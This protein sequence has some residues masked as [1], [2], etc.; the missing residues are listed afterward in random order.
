M[1]PNPPAPPSDA[2][3]LV[4]F[5]LSGSGKSALLGALGQVSQA[6][7][8]LL[9]GK[10]EDR[11]GTLA[12]AGGDH[13]KGEV[14]AHPIHYIPGQ[15]AGSTRD[16][17][18][19]LVDSAGSAASSL[20]T[21][22]KGLDDD[23]PEGS[24]AYEVGDADALILVLDASTPANQV[25]G[26]FAEFARF[27]ETVQ[28]ARGARTEVAGMPVFLVLNKCDK[29]SER[30]DTLSSWM[31]RIEQRKRDLAERFKAFLAEREDEEPAHP[32]DEEPSEEEQ[33]QE[34]QTYTGTFG[35]IELHVWATAVRK[36]DFGGKGGSHEPYGVAELFRQALAEGGEYQERCARAQRRLW[37]VSAVAVALVAVMLAI[38][39]GLFA[40]HRNTQ[41]TMLESRVRDFEFVNALGSRP[42]LRASVD[43]LRI[44]KS[45]LEEIEANRYYPQLEPEVRDRVES[46]H[47]EFGDYIAF[48]E[49]LEARRSPTSEQAESAL[50][51]SLKQLR[52]DRAAL[53]EKWKE[54]AVAPM[55]EERVRAGE[56]LQKAVGVARNW[57]LDSQEE[58]DRL[59]RVDGLDW[60]KW[61]EQVEKL[62][63]ASY[64]PPFRPN[65]PIPGAPGTSLTYAVAIRFDTATKAR[66]GWLDARKRLRRLF[67]LTSALKLTTPLEF[68]APP[69]L[70]FSADFRLAA[71]RPRLAQLEATYPEYKK[72]FLWDEV[73][74][75]LR[76]AVQKAARAQYE[77]LLKVG[78]DEVLARYRLS[79]KGEETAARWEAV[80]V[81]LNAPAELA[82]W[83]ELSLALLRVMSAT[84]EDPVTE[85][86]SFL[87]TKTFAV[88]LESVVVEVPDRSEL[89]P[90]AGARLIVLHPASMRQPALAFEDSGSEVRDEARGVV[91]YT[92]RRVGPK[93]LDYRPGDALWAE[94]PLAGG[95]EKLVW[96]TSRSQ[97]YLID[98]LRNPPLRQSVGATSLGEGKAQPEVRLTGRPEEGLPSVPDLLPA[99]NAPE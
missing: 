71:A 5:G 58:A 52:A 76:P 27:L 96:S 1:T 34:M 48:F 63:G 83:R 62:L 42:G 70:D 68:K 56:A 30:G 91:R 25:E 82:A 8:N 41:V 47:K 18:A 78:R 32:P 43:Q 54:T 66:E 46:T 49:T 17:E 60:T 97:L 23:S 55:L 85:L 33:I 79:G 74:A 61:S 15:A 84:V 12:G 95:K 14:T 93:R 40:L 21:R 67:A 28:K 86:A 98:R 26:Q 29:L 3:R 99:V 39:V 77:R 44:K 22:Q 36:P 50:E 4:L 16:I 51:E 59:L 64:R 11:L 92:F 87:G 24:L 9:G 2:L 35:R 53:P 37:F 13:P 31:E 75:R 81:W 65:E 94:L 6:R 38:T 72:E 7:D 90:R 73:P 57:Y 10:I 69:L 89:R 88:D 19:V 20:L 45:R 80:R